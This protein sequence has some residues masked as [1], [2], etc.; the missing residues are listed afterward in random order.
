MALRICFGTLI[1]AMAALAQ[2]TP[3]GK[4]PPP[5]SDSLIYDQVRQSLTFDADVRGAAIDVTVK[6]GVV[7][8]RGRVRDNKAREKALKLTKKVKGVKT[9]TN[10]LRLFSDKE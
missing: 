8:L 3:A 10:E 2:E 5:S 7:L 6:D 9:V 1:L 4:A